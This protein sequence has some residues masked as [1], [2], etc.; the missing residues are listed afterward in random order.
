[1]YH[2]VH[3]L[4]GDGTLLHHSVAEHVPGRVFRGEPHVLEAPVV[5]HLSVTD[6]VHKVARYAV[7]RII[8]HRI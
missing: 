7:S 1:M 4:L 5:A 2:L 8:K 3:M 6:A